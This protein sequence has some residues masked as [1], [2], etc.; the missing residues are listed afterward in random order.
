V[1][2]A[3]SALLAR[4]ALRAMTQVGSVYTRQSSGRYDGSPVKS[5]LKCLLQPVSRSTAPTAP[6]RAE[7]ANLGEFRWEP[8]YTMPADAQL[9]VDAFPGVRW[10]I[11]KGTVW[12]DIATGVTILQH[13]DV[14]RISGA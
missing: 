13:C 1:R 14:R 7:L 10:N 3:N 2:P 12:A 6:E 4:V 8:A 5:D 11:V 9:V